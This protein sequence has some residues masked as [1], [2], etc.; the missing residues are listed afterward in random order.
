[1]TTVLAIDQGTS[2]T[3]AVVVSPEGPLLGLA[4]VPVRPR[5]LS[6][7][8]VEQDPSELLDSVLAAGRE[9]VRQAG[10]AVDIVTLANQGET[11]LAWEPTT[12]KPLSPMVVWQDR[13]AEEIC[14]E[15][16]PHAERIAAAT[17]LVLDPYFSAPKQA[18]LRRHVTAEGVVT[19]SDS[20][21]LHQLTGEFVTDATTASR[22][23]VTD[24]ES[25]QW[26]AGLLDL[27]GL[28]Q[29]RLPRILASDA[30]AGSTTAFG[31]EALVGGLIVDQQAA[32]VAQ[33]CLAP[34]QAKCTFG[35]G[36][37]L[38]A[39]VGSS[40]TR[41]S[42]GLATSVAYRLGEQLTYCLDGQVY[43]AASAV[44]WLQDVGHID[45]APDLDRV[46]A[47]D[48]DGVIAVPAFAG[49]AAPWWRPDAR[50]TFTGLTLSTSRG[51]LVLAVLEGIAAQVAE[52]ASL[53]EHDL[54]GPLQRL[55][56]DGGLTQ[57]RVLMQAVANLMQVEID[58]YPSQHATPLG[59]AALARVAAD[60]TRSLADAVV[61]WAPSWTYEPQWSADRAQDFR[62]RWSAVA[63]ANC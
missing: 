15:L 61:P 48:D 7:G 62:A 47:E 41:S 36:A 60:P 16:R 19:T 56:V 10:V 21:L 20:W 37:F 46:S 51:H 54:D 26:D 29:E 23:L 11:V 30:V 18:W 6:G 40:P 4:E 55:R 12:G 9:A 57:S 33:N 14:E 35:T 1:M 58:V 63:T 28:G 3:K 25:G 42:A 50:A 24:L 34:G 38:L 39:N 52:L 8:G 31:K 43:T 45:S 27:F 13:R 32:L 49:L 2:G 59:A 17:G 44:R 22:S 5:Y 53:V